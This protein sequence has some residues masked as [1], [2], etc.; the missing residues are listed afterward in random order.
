MNVKD[1]LWYPYLRYQQECREKGKEDSVQEWLE[2]TGKVKPWKSPVKTKAKAKTSPKPKKKVVKKKSNPL[3]QVLEKANK[4]I[5]KVR[6]RNGKGH[7]VKDDP[8]TPENEAWV[9]EEVSPPTPP[10]KK[11]GR[12]RKKKES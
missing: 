1:Y 7:F 10:K 9:E 11:R 8:T 5:K 2:L 3:E 4:S 6:A 12:P